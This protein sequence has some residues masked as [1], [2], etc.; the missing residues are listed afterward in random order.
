MLTLEQF[1][2]WLAGQ[3]WSGRSAREIDA[4]LATEQ[5][6]PPGVDSMLLVA[7]AYALKATYVRQHLDD[8]S[9]APVCTIESRCSHSWTTEQS[10]GRV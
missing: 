3:P 9:A 2:A 10:V 8:L 6:T 1:D 5:N 4:A 7:I